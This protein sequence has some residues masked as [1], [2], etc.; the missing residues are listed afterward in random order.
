MAIG[1]FTTNEAGSHPQ[2]AAR[3]DLSCGISNGDGQQGSYLF[4]GPRRL[5]DPIASAA[6]GAVLLEQ[7]KVV[8]LTRHAAAQRAYLSP[9]YLAA[10]ERGSARPTIC[11]FLS[12][13]EA[14]GIDP[15]HL[16]NRWLARMN[17]PVGYRPVRT[18]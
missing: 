9:R 5:N 14:L 16:F 3:N 11:V 17:Y 6:L 18:A 1:K 13:A 4:M 10:L 15:R 12:L 2:V 8:E 7:R